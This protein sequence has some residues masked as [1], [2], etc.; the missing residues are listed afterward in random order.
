VHNKT[1]T[2]GIDDVVIG[3]LRR[4]KGLCI[5]PIVRVSG[6]SRS[7]FGFL[8]ATPL[9][10]LVDDGRNEYII[11]LTGGGE[12]EHLRSIID[13]LREEIEREIQ[14]KTSERT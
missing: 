3:G 13:D 8:A 5:I 11:P 4:V 14:K 2:E 12:T 9:C 6:A 1:P 7:G 10:L